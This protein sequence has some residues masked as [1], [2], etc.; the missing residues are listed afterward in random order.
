MGTR[1]VRAPPDA[2]P[3]SA[4][5]PSVAIVRLPDSDPAAV[6]GSSVCRGHMVA[7]AEPEGPGDAQVDLEV[8]V[9]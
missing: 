2:L 3:P 9:R 5:P 6:T 8:S 7:R 1:A 4:V